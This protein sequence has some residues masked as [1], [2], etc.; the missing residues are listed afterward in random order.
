MSKLKSKDGTL[1]AFDKSGKGPAVILVGG[2]LID[3][4]AMAPLAGLL[5]P[6]FT[7]FNFDRRGRGESGDTQPYAVQ[8]EIEDIDALIH[9]A[10]G[11]AALFGGSSGG[12][13]ALEAALALGGKVSGL[14][15]YEVPYDSDPATLPAYREYL[16]RLGEALATNRRGDAAAAFMKFV[17]TPDAQIEGMRRAPMWSVLEKVAPTL[18]YDAAVLG[19]DRP[20]PVQ[21]VARLGTPTLVING[22][23]IP[24]MRVTA[25]ALARAIPNA[26]QRT[27]EGQSHDV[28]PKVLAPVL[29]EFFRT[30]AQPT[31][32]PSNRYAG[33]KVGRS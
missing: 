32:Q 16:K 9:E 20:V 28:D 13:L 26:Q 15:M 27:L 23:V 24:F 31:Q 3:R 6:Q 1:I 21:R 8:R 11:A 10:G 25:E 17:G 12:A 33:E 2:A 4:Q 14:A 29:I 30:T 18:A 19:K 7:V 5:A 22:S